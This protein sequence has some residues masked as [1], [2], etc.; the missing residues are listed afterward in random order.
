MKAIHQSVEMYW[1]GPTV[2]GSAFVN[3]L[4][5]TEISDRD[6]ARVQHSQHSTDRHDIK[7]NTV[8]KFN[9]RER[10]FSFFSSYR[11]AL[12]FLTCF[13]LLHLDATSLTHKQGHVKFSLFYAVH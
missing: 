5:T 8:L 1:F 10:F 6:Q 2:R 12:G 11:D 13:D 4:K 7:T 9:T 3:G